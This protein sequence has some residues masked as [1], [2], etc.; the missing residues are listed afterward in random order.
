MDSDGLTIETFESEFGR[1]A[2]FEFAVVDMTGTAELPANNG[3][4]SVY[5]NP[6]RDQ[7]NIELSGMEATKVSAKLY[8]GSMMVV[9]EV[10]FN[11]IGS[12]HEEYINIADLPNGMYFLQ[13]QYGD[14]ISINKVV[15][16]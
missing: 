11:V 2:V 13:L 8:N 4:V 5:P 6:A 15:K 12:Y 3:I 16:Q 14:E 9:A 7:I 10:E 1:F